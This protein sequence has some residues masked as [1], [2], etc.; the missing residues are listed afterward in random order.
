M[1]RITFYDIDSRPI[2]KMLTSKEEELYL[3]EIKKD[4][5]Y[6]RKSYR[7]ASLCIDISDLDV[8]QAACKLIDSVRAHEDLRMQGIQ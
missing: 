7:R 8:S 6:F 1:K 5:T 2:E 4:I 3:R